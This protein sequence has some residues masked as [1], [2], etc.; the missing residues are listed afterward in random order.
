MKSIFEARI[1]ELF[2][3]SSLEE[4]KFIYI[5]RKNDE[6]VVELQMPVPKKARMSAWLATG[7][8]SSLLTA[9][10]ECIKDALKKKTEVANVDVA[11]AAHERAIRNFNDSN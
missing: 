7:I 1:E 11:E 3:I 6:Y 8:N 2:A 10:D 9:F 5:S 4:G